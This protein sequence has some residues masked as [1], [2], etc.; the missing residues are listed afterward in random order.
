MP[1]SKQ[2]AIDTICMLKIELPSTL[3]QKPRLQSV[4]DAEAGMAKHL[5][6]FLLAVLLI[7][8]TT[9]AQ[10]VLVACRSESVTA[11]ATPKNQKHVYAGG[12][13]AILPNLSFDSH[14]NELTATGH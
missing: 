11:V 2:H 10:S 6:I 12:A 14:T 5:R 1:I 9:L 13:P 3:G 8:G 4:E 7:A